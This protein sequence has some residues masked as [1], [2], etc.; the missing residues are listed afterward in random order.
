[1]VGLRP[2]QK[3]FRGFVEGD[4]LPL[5][6]S[7]ADL[8]S[9]SLR[10]LEGPELFGHGSIDVFPEPGLMADPPEGKVQPPGFTSQN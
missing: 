2:L 10:S 5:L 9:Q 3:F 1:V 4:V 6:P 8:S 7:N